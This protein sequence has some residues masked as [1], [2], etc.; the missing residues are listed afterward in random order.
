MHELWHDYGKLKYG[1]KAKCC[2]MGIDSFTE[3]MSTGDNLGK[4]G[5]AS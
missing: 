4:S 1:D 2:Y 5:L 3:Y